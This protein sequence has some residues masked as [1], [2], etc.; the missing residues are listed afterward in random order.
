VRK[1]IIWGVMPLVVPSVSVLW[2]RKEIRMDYRP[3]PMRSVYPV[4]MSVPRVQ[5]KCWQQK[6]RGEEERN[7]PRAP[8]R[9]I[10][11]QHSVLTLLFPIIEEKG[12]IPNQ[13]DRLF[14][15]AADVALFLNRGYVVEY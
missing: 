6:K 5:M 4:G 14:I 3:V 7:N 15:D 2:K 10:T 1:G 13:E 8:G 12:L 11:S 9:Y